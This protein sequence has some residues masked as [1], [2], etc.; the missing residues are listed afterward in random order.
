MLWSP[1][2]LQEHK[3]PPPLV[4]SPWLQGLALNQD[5]QLMRGAVLWPL[6]QRWLLQRV[7]EEGVPRTL[8][9]VHLGQQLIDQLHPPCQVVDKPAKRVNGHNPIP[10]SRHFAPSNVPMPPLVSYGHKPCPWSGQ[11]THSTCRSL[12]CR[13]PGVSP[14]TGKISLRTIPP[15]R[16][17]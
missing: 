15:S 9:A 6:D 5:Q 10:P 8:C 1:P 12:T 4:P 13:L 14:T 11:H 3:A 16:V 7:E 17:T 2:T